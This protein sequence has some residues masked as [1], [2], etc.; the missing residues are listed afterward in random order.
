MQHPT[1]PSAQCQLLSAHRDLAAAENPAQEPRPLPELAR[2]QPVGQ[3]GTSSSEHLGR[4]G[5]QASTEAPRSRQQ[6]AG[7][8][9][10]RVQPGRGAAR[11]LTL[12]EL[13]RLNRVQMRR[14]L[15]PP[16]PR[17]C[18]LLVGGCA[19]C[20][21]VPRV[22][23]CCLRPGPCMSYTL[24]CLDPDLRPILLGRC[25]PGTGVCSHQGV[26]DPGLPRFSLTTPSPRF[27]TAA[28]GGVSRF[29]PLP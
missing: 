13:V 20:P 25:F 5:L 23:P 14:R 15:R 11:G 29:L 26:G 10:N 3:S 2:G 22:R 8:E 18:A 27:P 4:T 16:P 9:G 6:A 12:S 21:A 17:G 24:A 28:A 7:T 1:R 19:P